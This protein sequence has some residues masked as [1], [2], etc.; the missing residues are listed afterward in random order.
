VEVLPDEVERAVG[1]GAHVDDPRDVL[2]LELGEHPR[3]APKT[4]DLTLVSMTREQ[5]LDHDPLVELGME[6]L[7]EEPV[8]PAED[9]PDAVLPSDD[10]SRM[11]FVGSH[12]C[13][14]HCRTSASGSAT[15]SREGARASRLEGTGAEHTRRASSL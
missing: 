3:L 11:N 1:L 5:D 14:S 9:G 2:R 12:R 13:R 6:A 7:E 15:S 8:V 10:I 4:L